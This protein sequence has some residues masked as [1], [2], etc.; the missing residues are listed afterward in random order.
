VQAPIASPQLLVASIAVPGRQKCERPAFCKYLKRRARANEAS[1]TPIEGVGTG[2][3]G[4]EV[5][6]GGGSDRNGSSDSGRQQEKQR[7]KLPA[8]D[9]L[10]MAELRIARQAPTLFM[11]QSRENVSAVSPLD[12]KLPRVWRLN[13]DE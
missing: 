4:W 5:V 9:S 11:I 8:R 13:I 1:T 3:R 12:S 7:S 6:Y 2:E 10:C